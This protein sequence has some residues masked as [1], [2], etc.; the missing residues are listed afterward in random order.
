MPGTNIGGQRARDTNKRKYGDDHY[1]KIGSKGGSVNRPQTRPF[2]NKEL[3]S[4]AG[5]LG[6]IVTGDQYKT[7]SKDGK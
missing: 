4:K 6:G 5:Y 7:R 3:A 2:A 1:A